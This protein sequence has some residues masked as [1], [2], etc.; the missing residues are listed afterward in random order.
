[1]NKFFSVFLLALYVIAAN[2]KLE[3]S[4]KKV[5]TSGLSSKRFIANSAIKLSKKIG[6]I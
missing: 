2:G 1:M 4:S 3:V 6:N 5:S